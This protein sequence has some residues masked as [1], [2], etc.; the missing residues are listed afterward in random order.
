MSLATTAEA[1]VTARRVVVT[2]WDTDERLGDDRSRGL[3][4]VDGVL[5]LTNP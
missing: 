3:R 5:K 2:E 4:I 1:A